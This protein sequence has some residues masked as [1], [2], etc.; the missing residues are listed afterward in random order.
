MSS[1]GTRTFADGSTSTYFTL[2]N[3]EYIRKFAWGNGWNRIR[4]G[5]LYAVQGGVTFSL[6]QNGLGVCSSSSPIDNTQGQKSTN[7]TQWAGC[8]LAG[9]GYGNVTLTYNAGP[10]PY[11]TYND[12]GRAVKQVNSYSPAAFGGPGATYVGAAGGAASYRGW[13][14]VDLEKFSGTYWNQTGLF[15][16]FSLAQLQYNITMQELT[17]GCQQLRSQALSLRGAAMTNQTNGA[18]NPF[19]EQTPADSISIYWSATATPMEVYGIAAYT[20]FET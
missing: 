16:P 7:T 6:V 3:E 18:L 14:F 19:V 15:L 8:F 20:H 9:A 2:A 4:I 12:A 11:Y 5:I 1:F 10:P 17:Y 13:M